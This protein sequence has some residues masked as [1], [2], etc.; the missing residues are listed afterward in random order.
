MSIDKKILKKLMQGDYIHEYTTCKGKVSYQGLIDCIYDHDL[1]KYNLYWKKTIEG[2]D[3]WSLVWK[4]GH[5]EES[6]RSL[7]LMAM[8]VGLKGG[9]S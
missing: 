7:Q 4:D 9:K 8:V 6:I 3:Y 2:H 1:L 5:S